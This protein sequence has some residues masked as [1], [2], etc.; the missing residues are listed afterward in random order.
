L[1]L[2]A[3]VAPPH[4]RHQQDNDVPRGGRKTTRTAR[5]ETRKNSTSNGETRGRT[6]ERSKKK[7]KKDKNPQSTLVVC[8]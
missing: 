3:R 5:G 7:K 8:A 2:R 4:D 1:S 6:K